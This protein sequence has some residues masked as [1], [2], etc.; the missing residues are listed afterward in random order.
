MV[1]LTQFLPF[2]KFSTF[3]EA[4]DYIHQNKAMSNSQIT[5]QID[6]ESFDNIEISKFDI[7]AYTLN[8]LL[9]V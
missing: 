9:W 6:T 2:T 7:L 4:Q 1:E 8:R 5:E 3:E